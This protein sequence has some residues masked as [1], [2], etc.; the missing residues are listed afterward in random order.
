MPKKILVVEDNADTLEVMSALLRMEGYVVVTAENGQEGIDVANSEQPHL[1]ITDINMP[2]L[3]GT[4]MIKIL[5]KSPQF[6]DTPIIAVTAYG[7]DGAASARQAGADK[8]L[9]KPVEYDLFRDYIR[10]LLD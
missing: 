7:M 5:R 3:C 6:R 8:V 1:I 2:V 4:D 10:S 9:V